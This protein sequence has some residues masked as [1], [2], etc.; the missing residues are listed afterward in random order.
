[1]TQTARRRSSRDVAFWWLVLLDAVLWFAAFAWHPPALK[2]PPV[3]AINVWPGAESFIA[4]RELNLIP[5]REINFVEMGWTSPVMRSLGNHAV[6]AAILSLSE[7]ALLRDLDTPLRMMLAVDESV[8]GDALLVR[9]E[10]A[11]LTEISQL[12]GRRVAV[13]VRSPGHYLLLRS[14]IEAG[15]TLEDVEIVPINQPE[16]ETA[17]KDFKVDVVATAEPWLTK[18]KR[19]GGHI[20]SDSSKYPGEFLRVLVVRE[21]L[22]SS[23]PESLKSMVNAHFKLLET[24]PADWNPQIAAGIL[25]RERLSMEQYAEAASRVRIYSRNDQQGLITGENPTI[26]TDYEKVATYL[27]AGGLIK[28]QAVPPVTLDSTLIRP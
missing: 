23:G 4:A 25:R 24:A 7:V 15:L 22:A 8:G 18:L 1:M 2:S 20:L 16:S 12:K 19:H 5:G 28:Q 21:E 27:R 9:P 10:L 3:V 13:E 11:D 6:D 14:L 17:F 26:A